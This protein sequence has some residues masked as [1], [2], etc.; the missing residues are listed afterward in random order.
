M[1]LRETEEGR[2]SERSEFLRKHN[3]DT[4]LIRHSPK[5]EEP[6]KARSLSLDDTYNWSA[7]LPF[8]NIIGMN[9]VCTHTH[10]HTHCV[11]TSAGV[12]KSH[13]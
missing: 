6:P 2:G 1:V 4:F 12:T 9:C 5:E 10:T 13:W 3:I 11:Y 7:E 8:G